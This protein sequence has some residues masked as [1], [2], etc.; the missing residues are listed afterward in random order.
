MKP[1]FAPAV[2]LVVFC[3]VYVIVFALD[4][5]LF[6]Y[7]PLHGAFSFGS[8]TLTGAGPAMAWYGLVAGAGGVAA[9]TALII[10]NR[11]LDTPL[12]NRLWLFPLATMLSC[13]YLLRIFFR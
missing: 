11:M 12:R 6:R 13:L 7:Y 2:F 4:R 10:P 9:L 8:A 1:R 5:P 3:C